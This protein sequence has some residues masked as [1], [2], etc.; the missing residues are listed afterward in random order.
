M[1]FTLPKLPYAMDALKPF[2][3]EEQIDFHYNKHHNA[4]FTKLNGMVDGKPEADQSL[5]QIVAAS[6]GGL[7]NNAAQAYN[8]TFFWN[9]M[10]PSGGGAPK[11]DLAAAIDRDF[12]GFDAFK[13]KFSDAAATLFGSGWAWLAKDGAGKLEILAL[14]NADT[15]VKHG[16]SAVLTLDVWEHAYYIDYRNLRPKFIEGF[17]G[18]ANWDHAAAAYAGK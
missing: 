4:Y 15:P 10:D 7:F 17:W 11:G 5:E 1:A 3:S 13:A 14:P 9:S 2:L 18:V 16:K 8:H 6:S 12:G